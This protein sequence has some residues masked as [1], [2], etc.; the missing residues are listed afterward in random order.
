MAMGEGKL[1]A[2]LRIQDDL[3][4]HRCELIVLV[5]VVVLDVD[6]EE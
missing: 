2:I 4:R 6:Y 3:S 5:L 1:A